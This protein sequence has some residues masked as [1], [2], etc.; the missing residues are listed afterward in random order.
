MLTIGLE[1]GVDVDDARRLL[2]EDADPF[3][4]ILAHGGGRAVDL[5]HHRVDQGGPGGISTTFTRAPLPPGDL[6]EGRAQP[7][8]DV[9]ALGLALVLA[10]QV[11]LEVGSPGQAAQGIVPIPVVRAVYSAVKKFAE[12]VFSD[13]SE[14]F[15]NVLLIEYPRKGL[16]SLAFQTSSVSG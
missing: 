10:S 2:E 16:Y 8:G 12:M 1:G 5:R 4:H 3:G 14:S 9:V 11:H 15:K 6:L 13:K 7:L